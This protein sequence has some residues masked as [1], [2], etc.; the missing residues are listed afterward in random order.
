M[1]KNHSTIKTIAIL[2]YK[3]ISSNSFKN[4]L[5][6][7]LFPYKSYAYQFKCVQIDYKL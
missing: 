1:I 6:D 4:E 2:V 7:K 3:W 5:T